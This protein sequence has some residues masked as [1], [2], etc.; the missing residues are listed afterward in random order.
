MAVNNNAKPHSLT[1]IWNMGF[2]QDNQLPWI[3]TLEMT[4]GNDADDEFSRKVTKDLD[5]EID[6]TT[7]ENVT[8]VGYAK[9]GT[10]TS[11]PYWRIFKL[12]EATGLQRHYA[13]SNV[14]FDNI[15]DNRG[16]LDY[17]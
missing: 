1:H 4:P 2:D 14:E 8:Y 12:D 15:W 16:T 3:E 9:P 17:D 13:D 7:T 5:I 6:D 11:D 10:A